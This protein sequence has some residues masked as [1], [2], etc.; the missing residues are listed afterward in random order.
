MTPSHRSRFRRIAAIVLLAVVALACGCDRA[1]RPREKT[2]EQVR[3]ELRRL[4]PAT[5][6]DR[7]GWAADIQAAFAA[8][9]IEP[10][11]AN[12]CSVLAVTEQE[13]TF[14]ADPPVSGLGRIALEE[15]DR[16]MRERHIP[17]LVARAALQFDSPDGR[18]WEQ[19]IAA[20]TS[21]RELS[22]VYEAMID[23]V[24]M[25]RR[26]LSNSNPVRT[27]GP[28]QVGIA[29]AEQLAKEKDYPYAVDGSI[30]REVFTRRGGMYFGIA[31]LLGYR[32]SYTRPIHRFADFNAGWYASR[33]AAFQH[34]VT[35]ATGIEL[36]E[37]GDLVRYDSDEPSRTEVAVRVL[38]QQLG[39]T[40]A[41][42][43]RALR[44]ARTHDFEETDLYHQVFE[45]ADHAAGRELPRAR[46]PQIRLSSPKITRKLTTEWFATRVDARYRRCMARAKG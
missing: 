24:P 44:K 37:D 36:D 6:A 3:A 39:M 34:A 42:I 46:I 10:S 15:I 2:P 35:V 11:T 1:P 31:H 12:L 8:L 18:T 27:G 22:N 32:A 25:G 45:L 43:H 7:D 21:E 9:R 19:R 14:T 20:A 41:Q 33:N 38:S 30:R 23:R 28:M 29:F 16:R 17:P 26:L 5:L 4:L 13:S 40:D